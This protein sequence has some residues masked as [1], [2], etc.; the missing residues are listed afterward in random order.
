M[1][2]ID[3]RALG[4]SRPTQHASPLARR[5]TGEIGTGSS[6]GPTGASTGGTH[7]SLMAG[8]IVGPPGGTSPTN[9]AHPSRAGRHGEV[10]RTGGPFVGVTHTRPQRPPPEYAGF[11]DTPDR[12]PTQLLAR[13]SPSNHSSATPIASSNPPRRMVVRGTP[14]TISRPSNAGATA[15][16]SE[17]SIPTRTLS[18]TAGLASSFLDDISPPN[19]VTNP[20]GARRTTLASSPDSLSGSGAAT[21]CRQSPTA[22]IEA[23]TRVS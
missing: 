1:E 5:G 19:V 4:V 12:G 18:A 13:A 14:G 10:L 11:L 7:T 20:L 9:A 22:Q 23:A 21:A 16:Q 17:E 8:S 2:G 3:R 15:G 6:K